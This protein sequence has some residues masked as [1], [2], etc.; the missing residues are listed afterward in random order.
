MESLKA[1]LMS[2]LEQEQGQLACGE[3]VRGSQA[4]HWPKGLALRSQARVGGGPG[5]NCSLGGHPPSRGRPQCQGRASLGI[6]HSAWFAQEPGTMR[7]D[8]SLW[9]S[10]EMRCKQT[11]SRKLKGKL[12]LGT[13]AEEISYSRSCSIFF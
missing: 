4:G 11:A 10:G 8:H 3:A 5:G 2:S 13:D 9:M 7:S 12:G 6:M 1:N